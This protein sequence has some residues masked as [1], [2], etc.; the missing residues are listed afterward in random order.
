MTILV[1]DC[2]SRERMRAVAESFL[3]CGHEGTV[4][5]GIFD[6]EECEAS[7]WDN[8]VEVPSNVDLVVLHENNRDAFNERAISGRCLVSYTG[9]NPSPSSP[10]KLWIQRPLTESHPLRKDEARSILEWLETGEDPLLLPEVLGSPL[11]LPLQVLAAAY[12]AGLRWQAGENNSDLPAGFEQAVLR[13]LAADQPEWD[14]MWLRTLDVLDRKLAEAQAIEGVPCLVV[15]PG[16]PP[17]FRGAVACLHK[18]LSS[19]QDES[20]VQQWNRALTALRDALL[21]RDGGGT[22]E[23]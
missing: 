13:A 21:R 12:Y 8:G 9:G 7:D 16:G 15:E 22:E 18:I 6:D 19:A 1:F 10:G 5:Y 17:S 20:G 4:V 11:E 2:A 23:G 3:N 14:D